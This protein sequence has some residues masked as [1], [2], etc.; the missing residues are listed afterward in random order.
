VECPKTHGFR[1]KAGQATNQSQLRF[2]F[3]E[4]HKKNTNI[5]AFLW[6]MLILTSEITHFQQITLSQKGGL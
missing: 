6:I 4:N 3:D 5:L 2:I 1:F